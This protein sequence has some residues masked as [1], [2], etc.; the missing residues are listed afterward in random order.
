MSP[1][2][3]HYQFKVNLDRVDSLSN[4]DFNAAEIDWFLNEAQLIF[5]KQR[6]SS[7]SNSKQKGF[8]ESQKRI[9][10]LGNLVIKFPLQTGITPIL[11]SPGIYELPLASLTYPYLFL[12]DTW[13]EIQVNENCTK[14]VPLRFVQHDD[15]LQAV[16]DPFY[17]SHEEFI[18]YNIGR[19]SV[20]GG[21]S[22][23]IYSSFTVN[24]V[25]VEYIKYPAKISLGT[26]TYID[27]VTYPEQTLESS[28][29]THQ[30]IVDL[31]CSLAGLSTQNPEYIQLRQTKLLINE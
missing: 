22:I 15:Y 11:V 13:V 27:G 2:E 9:D 24:S 14:N 30:E 7:R 6:M 3:L 18:P 5:V 16:K 19:S 8:E 23:Y 25:F 4:P 28:V 26:Y 21:E 1:R 29:Q 12:L 31:A 20:L 17:S 10:D